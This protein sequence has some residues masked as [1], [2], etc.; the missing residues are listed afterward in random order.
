MRRS[1]PGNTEG[2]RALNGASSGGNS[3]ALARL[4]RGAPGG[5]IQLW[6]SSRGIVGAVGWRR[7]GQ[8]FAADDACVAIVPS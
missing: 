4:A 2:Q 5:G 3:D 1:Q 6:W 8:I 7:G